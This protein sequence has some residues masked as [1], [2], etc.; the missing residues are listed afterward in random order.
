MNQPAIKLYGLIKKQKKF[1]NAQ[2]LENL[3]FFIGLQTLKINSNLAEYVAY[4]LLKI[5]RI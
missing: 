2:L 3:G 4:N 5:N 1:K